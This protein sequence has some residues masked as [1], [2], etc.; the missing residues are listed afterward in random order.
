LFLSILVNSVQQCPAAVPLGH[1]GYVSFS[2][3][4]Y[5]KKVSMKLRPKTIIIA[6]S[7]AFLVLV[8][9]IVF[10][11]R[12]PVLVVTE[13]SF[14]E[15]YGE[16]RL[17]SE[18]AHSSFVLFR[19]VKPVAVADDAGDD[20]ILAAINGA[21]SKP[22]CVL[23]PL[24]FAKTARDYREKN[25]GIPVVLLEGRYPE[26]VNPASFA[27]GGNT[28]DYF[29]YR[30]DIFADF[31]RAGLAA[32]ILDGEKN[33]KIAVFLESSIQTQAKEA[34]SKALND[35]GK[36]LQTYFF[37]AYSQFTGNQD[38]SCVVLTGTGA[39]Y[40]DKYSDLPVIFFTWINPE[41]MP[42]DVVLVFDDSPWIQAVSAVRMAKAGMTKGQIPSKILFTGGKGVDRG[43]SRKL[44]KI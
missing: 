35:A 38:I 8:I 44:R 9:F 13:I 12:S 41:M 34:L 14:A 6:A 24:R 5:N 23:F 31:Y 17:L 36:P 4:W 27:I 21:S 42:Q 2:S 10:F 30:T 25:P 32:A 40:L 39:D 43:A 16:K 19:R 1:G 20:I 29:I 33:E 18:T 7:L 11:V 15:I 28:E 22:F 3:I 37:T 26:G